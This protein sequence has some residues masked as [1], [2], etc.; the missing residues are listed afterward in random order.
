MELDQQ[1]ARKEAREA[2]ADGLWFVDDYIA[3]NPTLREGYPVC[4]S[5]D[6]FEMLYTQQTLPMLF[7][8]AD[9]DE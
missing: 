5:S 9:A 1:V 2:S 3:A 7:D 8:D 4:P 6:Y